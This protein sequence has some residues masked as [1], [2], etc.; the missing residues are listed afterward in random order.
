MNTLVDGSNCPIHK[1]VLPSHSALYSSFVTK[2]PH[3]TLKIDCAR[4]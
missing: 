2:L 3:A 4:Q 1:M